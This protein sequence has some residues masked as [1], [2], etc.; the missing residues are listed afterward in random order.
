MKKIVAPLALVIVYGLLVMLSVP[1]G[2]VFGSNI[3]WLCQHVAL[4]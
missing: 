4:A 2:H 3:D 1:S